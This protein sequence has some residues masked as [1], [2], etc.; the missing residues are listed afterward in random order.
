V[1]F[2]VLVDTRKARVDKRDERVNETGWE[3]AFE[4]RELES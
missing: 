4:K 3:E 2:P 1:T